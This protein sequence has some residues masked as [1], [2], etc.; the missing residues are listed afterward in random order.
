MEGIFNTGE[1][2]IGAQIKLE[3][4]NTGKILYIKRFPN[5]GKL[6]INIPKEPY[7]IVLNGGPRYIIKKKGLAPIEGFSTKVLKKNK[8]KLDSEIIKSKRTS[9]LPIVIFGL[10]VAF[11]LLLLTIFI[12]MRNTNKL[13]RELRKVQS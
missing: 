2:A 12:S 10:A 13:I 5:K 1:L 11:L 3:S 6:I 4:I 9:T 7:I 8:T